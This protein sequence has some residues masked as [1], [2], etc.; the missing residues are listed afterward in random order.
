MICDSRALLNSIATDTTMSIP[1][2]LN[3]PL[4]SPLL[5]IA[6]STIDGTSATIARKNAPNSVILL[7]IFFR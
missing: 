4:A 2:A 5:M 7:E 6:L 3:A 1:V